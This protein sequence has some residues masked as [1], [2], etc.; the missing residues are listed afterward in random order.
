[1]DNQCSLKF[2]NEIHFYNIKVN[3]AILSHI[4]YLEMII[5]ESNHKIMGCID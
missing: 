3:L 5:E 2:K 4:K 1:M